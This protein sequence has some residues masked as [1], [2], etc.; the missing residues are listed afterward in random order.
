MNVLWLL[1]KSSAKSVCLVAAL[2]VYQSLFCFIFW[3]RQRASTTLSNNH[4]MDWNSRQNTHRNRNRGCRGLWWA[5]RGCQEELVTTAAP[6]PCFPR[7]LSE[8]DLLLLLLLF[9]FLSLGAFSF[10]LSQCFFFSEASRGWTYTR[11]HERTHVSM[12]ARSMLYY[13]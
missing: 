12:H 13:S 5:R 10:S 4:R 9:L 2:S 7:K 3:H 1:I 11:I 8:S 6:S